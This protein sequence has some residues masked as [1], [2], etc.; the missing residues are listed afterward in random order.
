MLSDKFQSKFEDS[1]T[2]FRTL[3]VNKNVGS[4]LKWNDWMR[5]TMNYV[6][7]YNGSNLYIANL[8]TSISDTTYSGYGMYR[9]QGNIQRFFIGLNSVPVGAKFRLIFDLSRCNI[10]DSS[11]V[12]RWQPYKEVEG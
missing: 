12:V 10:T 2:S 6:D 11:N 7:S 1:N 9:S 4:L 8:A 5:F 3:Q